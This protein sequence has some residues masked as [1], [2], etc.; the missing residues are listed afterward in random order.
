MLLEIQTHTQWCNT[1]LMSFSL[2]LIYHRSFWNRWSKHFINHFRRG[3]GRFY[4]L[5]FVHSKV[6]REIRIIIIRDCAVNDGI[7]WLFSFFFLARNTIKN[8]II[9]QHDE[10]QIN[11]CYLRFAY[12]LTICSMLTLFAPNSIGTFLLSTNTIAKQR[13]FHYATHS[14]QQ[15]SIFV[16]PK[17]T[18][19]I[20]MISGD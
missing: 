9:I 3:W 1:H 17:Q 12:W 2:G 19:Q 7:I 20:E 8:W 16:M 18:E 13:N 11:L 5:C 15:Q 10:N 6:E 4:F 14:P